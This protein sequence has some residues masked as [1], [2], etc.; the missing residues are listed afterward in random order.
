MIAGCNRLA[1]VYGSQEYR[2]TDLCGG[3]FHDWF[4]TVSLM[5][6]VASGKLVPRQHGTAPGAPGPVQTPVW[7]QGMN[8]KVREKACDD[9]GDLIDIRRDARGTYYPAERDSE[10]AHRCRQ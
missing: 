5:R 7:V 2:R 10:Q 1:H 8:V 9:C 3:C 4:R 6:D